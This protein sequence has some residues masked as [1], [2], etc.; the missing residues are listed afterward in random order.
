MLG[1]VV[2]GRNE[3]TRLQT[4]LR[5]LI[6]CGDPIV[7]VDSGS[8]DG[9]V[10]FARSLNIEI[11]EL[12]ASGGFSAGRARHAGF[13]QLTSRFPETDFVFF[14]D[15]DCGVVRNWPALGAQFLQD[16]PQV[17]AVAGRRRE[18]F[19]R[20]S[21]F[22]LECDWEWD[23]PT[24]ETL[25]LGGDGIYRANAYRAAGGFDA[26]VSAGEEPE[27]CNRLRQQGWSIWRVADE[28]TIHNADIT[29]WP[30]W[31][32][33]QFRTGYGGFDVERRFHLQL[34]DRIL[35]GAAFWSVIYPAAFVVASLVV[36]TLFGA[37]AAI[38]VLGLALFGWCIQVLRIA[39]RERRPGWLLP[40]TI[41]IACL[42][43]LAK[44]P[45]AIGAGFAS[46]N[47]WRGI[48]NRIVEYK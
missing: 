25:A 31:W 39:H 26:T 13:E 16:H 4:C 11:I 15:G 45:I 32:K 28:M 3:G 17:A 43:M 12:D 1:I 20:Q 30:Q 33:R 8:T 7:Y 9:S 40:D 44:L 34:F 37:P 41:K 35:R 24:G 22:N 6:A 27:L 38:L 29:S 42:M 48:G 14:V 5:S 19:P 36:A 2:I 21:W 47:H 23:R 10:D 18:R 46:L